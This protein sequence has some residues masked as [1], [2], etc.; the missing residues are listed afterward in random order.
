MSDFK[1]NN[2]TLSLEQLELKSNLEIKKLLRISFEYMVFA[3]SKIYSENNR[4]TLE[5]FNTTNKLSLSKIISYPFF[6]SLSNGHSKSLYGLFGR[7]LA[8]KYSP[9]SY[10]LYHM[11]VN[12][13]NSSLFDFFEFKSSNFVQIKEIKNFSY[14]DELGDAIKKVELIIDK[15][16]YLFE[17]VHIKSDTSETKQLFKAIESGINVVN[18]QSN[19]QFFNADL[20]SL[21]LQARYF[22]IFKQYNDKNLAKIIQFTDLEKDRARPYYNLAD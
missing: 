9:I 8:W 16:T 18:S 22:K 7:F 1:E 19:K 4:L 17:N 3:I 2:I 20:N 5:S 15:K 6:I 21:R 10:D 14:W 13:D 12:E 11:I